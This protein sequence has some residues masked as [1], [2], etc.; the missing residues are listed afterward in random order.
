M[1]NVPYEA[2]VAKKAVLFVH[3]LDVTLQKVLVVNCNT[4]AVSDVRTP[5]RPVLTERSDW[6]IIYPIHQA[7]WRRP[8]DGRYAVQAR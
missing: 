4:A 8:I 6:Y 2:V 1:I 5:H 3:M 7:S